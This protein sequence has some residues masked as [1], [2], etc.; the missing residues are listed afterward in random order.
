[1]QKLLYYEVRIL[2]VLDQHEWKTS[3]DIE[4]VKMELVQVNPF[5]TNFVFTYKISYV[6]AI[7]CIVYE[8]R[9][10]RTNQ[11]VEILTVAPVFSLNSDVTKINQHQV[12]PGP[13]IKLLRLFLQIEFS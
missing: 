1:M 11:N 6:V 3:K 7:C 4:N 9:P 10:K 13:L 8:S 2:E 5:L 12:I